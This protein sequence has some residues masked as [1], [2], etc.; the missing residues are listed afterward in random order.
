MG[1]DRPVNLK[2]DAATMVVGG[3]SGFSSSSYFS[4]VVVATRVN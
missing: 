1:L 3:F 4:E 2:E